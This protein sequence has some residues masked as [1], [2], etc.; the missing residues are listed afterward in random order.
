MSE[1]GHTTTAAVPLPIRQDGGAR[2]VKPARDDDDELNEDTGTGVASPY[3]APS[4]Y[5]RPLSARG[6]GGASPSA[7]GGVM[8]SGSGR[9]GER[10]P[11]TALDREQIEGLVSLAFFFF[12]FGDGLGYE[13]W[14]ECTRLTSVV[15]AC[16]SR[17][18]QGAH[19]LRCPPS[20]L[21]THRLRHFASRE[22]ESE[23]SNPMRYDS[24]T[25]LHTYSPEL[26]S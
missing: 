3:V 1:E 18:P 13:V 9:T 19:E 10:A 6:A 4:S 15:I 24:S 14:L 2:T 22:E 23:C 5:L 25:R 11:L 16:D 20:Q 21:P 26:K 7:G 17:F 8:R 12:V